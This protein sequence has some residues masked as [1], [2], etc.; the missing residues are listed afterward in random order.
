M[1][2]A[3]LE[4]PES[5][6]ETHL[7]NRLGYSDP[8]IAVDVNVTDA[9][10]DAM[11][12]HVIKT[13]SRLGVEEPYWS[14][15]SSDEFRTREKPSR[16][17]FYALGESDRDEL[18]ATLR[19][20]QIELSSLR[21]CLELGCGV[22]RTTWQLAQVFDRVY[23]FDVSEP[24]LSL[25]KDWCALNK[26][27]NVEFSQGSSTNALETLPSVDVVYSTIVLQHNPPP[28]MASMLSSAL[29]CLN[30]GGVAVVQLPTY[31]RNYSFDVEQYLAFAQTNTA[32]EM[33]VLP[34]AEV[35]RVVEAEGCRTMEVFEDSWTGLAPKTTSNTF[36]IQRPR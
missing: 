9:Q 15:I 33:H 30:P 18:L 27:V 31:D 7:G 14:V 3:V 19:R 34:Q 8:P 13:W 6:A 4:R 20:N 17:E 16:A 1:R 11:L 2:A 10:L 35:F 36:V 22:G 28:V 32:I 24:H 12:G 29:R 26:V 25:A 21:T 23:G 5:I